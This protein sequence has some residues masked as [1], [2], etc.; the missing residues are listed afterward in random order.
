M[1]RS[2]QHSHAA[3]PDTASCL[4]NGQL[5]ALGDFEPD[6]K[7]HGAPVAMA[8]DAGRGWT[9]RQ[10]SSEAWQLEQWR[11]RPRMDDWPDRM[12]LYEAAAY[13]R[14]SY[15]TI[16]RLCIQDRCG[17]ATLPHQRVGTS[18]RIRRSDLDCLGAVAGRVE[19]N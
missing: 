7:K 3:A 8:G 12:D 13:M 1:R 19:G 9:H 16:R 10:K 14:S 2:H 17:R 4:V 15:D 18:Y 11:M 5:V 6:E